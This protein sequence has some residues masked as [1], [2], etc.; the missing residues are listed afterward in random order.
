M[1][2]IE[3]A[4]LGV[5]AR[6]AE[7]KISKTGKQYLRFTLRVGA[8]DSVQWVSV[9]AFD[10]ASIVIERKWGGTEAFH[11]TRFDPFL[12]RNPNRPAIEEECPNVRLQSASRRLAACQS[13]RQTGDDG[14]C[15]I[16]QPWLRLRRRT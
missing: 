10:P 9:L 2:G 16:D 11:D 1:S 15:E 6:D 4:M 8:D 12:E 7:A 3:A 13:R 14:L 5:L